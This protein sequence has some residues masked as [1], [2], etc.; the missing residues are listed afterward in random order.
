MPLVQVKENENSTDIEMMKPNGTVLG[1]KS[2]KS[3]QEVF[4]LIC[5]I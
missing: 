1:L 3:L 2:E 5:T 4:L